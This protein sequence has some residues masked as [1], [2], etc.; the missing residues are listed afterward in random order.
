MKGKNNKIRTFAMGAGALALGA[1]LWGQAAQAI[2]MRAVDFSPGSGHFDFSFAG[3]AGE[4]TGSACASC[5][6]TSFA[7]TD[8]FGKS[9]SSTGV[10]NGGVTSFSLTFDTAGAV[11]GWR[12]GL[13]SYEVSGCP[14]EIG[15]RDLCRGT[16]TTTELDSK[17]FTQ[18][19]DFSWPGFR[20]PPQC[21]VDPDT[22]E[23]FCEPGAATD[24]GEQ[25]VAR[26]AQVRFTSTV[27]VPSVPEPGSAALVGLAL[28]GLTRARRA[29]RKR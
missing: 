14:T 27:T 9:W 1:M 6:L 25:S 13:T 23:T 22:G 3:G 28:V 12:I 5:V 16:I 18:R 29:S 15:F 17:L 11:S 2:P 20:P 4:F 26:R 19:G 21:F 24:P 8:L 10:G 7:V